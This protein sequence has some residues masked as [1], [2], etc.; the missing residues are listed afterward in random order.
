LVKRTL[1]RSGR[2]DAEASVVHQ[3][4][5]AAVQAQYFLDGSFD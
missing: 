2:G 1:F 4:V 3:Q 5:D